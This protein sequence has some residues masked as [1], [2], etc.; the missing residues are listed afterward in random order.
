[1][2]SASGRMQALINDLLTFSRVTTGARP[3]QNVDLGATVRDVLADLEVRITDTGGRVDVADL[4]RVEADPMQMRQLMQNLIG[5]ALKYRRDGVAPEVRVAA[6][7]VPRAGAEAAVCEITIADNGIGF[8]PEH[9]ERIFG[10]FQRLHGRGEYEGTGVG[11]AV[12]RKI[13]ERH[14]G[15]IRAEGKPGEGA[16][17]V[18]ELPLAQARERPY[19]TRRSESD[20]DRNG[21]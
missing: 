21:R 16:T 8:E 20:H 10:M 11:L 12:C 13:V 19:E 18:V 14:G 6:R 1:M 4:P 2:Q 15:K 17:F 5:N 9:A 3:F 7:Q